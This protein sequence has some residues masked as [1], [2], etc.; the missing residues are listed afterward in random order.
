MGFEPGTFCMHAVGCLS[1][2]WCS[3]QS[4][5]YFFL[6]DHQ[7]PSWRCGHCVGVEI[8]RS[9]VRVLSLTSMIF[10]TWKNLS[11]FCRRTASS[12]GLVNNPA[13]AS[14]LGQVPWPARKSVSETTKIGKECYNKEQNTLLRALWT[15]RRVSNKPEGR[16][17]NLQGFWSP[18][19]KP[20]K[21]EAKCFA[22]ILTW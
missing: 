20:T 13:L 16:R 17:P 12:L 1:S 4:G 7:L 11:H 18:E 8:R 21:P 14:G 10:S 15:C 3:A 5:S 22:P 9:R 2:A 6:N 19:G